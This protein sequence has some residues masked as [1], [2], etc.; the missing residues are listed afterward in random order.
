MAT[1]L[2]A[3]RVDASDGGS[4]RW[5][6]KSYRIKAESHKEAMVAAMERAFPAKKLDGVRVLT[7]VCSRLDVVE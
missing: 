3:I 4:I 2:I 7:I 6:E 1:Y 5:L